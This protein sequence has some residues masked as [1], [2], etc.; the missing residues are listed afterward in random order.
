M[1]G[2]K[3]ARRTAISQTFPEVDL[4][5]AVQTV[6]QTTTDERTTGVETGKTNDARKRSKSSF[7]HWQKMR[8]TRLS[9]H[10]WLYV[11]LYGRYIWPQQ[12]NRVTEKSVIVR[13]RRMVNARCTLDLADGV[14]DSRWLHPSNGAVWCMH[15][16]HRSCNSDARVYTALC[17]NVPL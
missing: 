9:A 5:L 14:T 12:F 4:W 8:Y 13:G 11:F 10:G 6:I 16:N 1:L 2:R 7:S 17:R 15:L 3:I